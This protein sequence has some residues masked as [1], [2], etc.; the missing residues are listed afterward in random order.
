MNPVAA[1]LLA[2]ASAAMLVLALPGH[3]Q[4]Y[5]SFVAL[6]PLLLVIQRASARAALL[7]AWL[8]GGVFFLV[9]LSWIAHLT[10][11]GL[12]ALAFYLSLSFLLFAWVVRRLTAGPWRLPFLAVAPMAWVAFEQLRGIPLGGF[13]WH[14]L[15][16]NL[17]RWTTL[18]Q[19]ADVAGVS[20]LSLVVAFAGAWLARVIHVA[21][22]RE[23][24]TRLAQRNL[25]LGALLAFVLIAGTFVYGRFRLA[26]TRLVDG[27]VVS[28]VQANIPQE[29]S[30]IAEAREWP[31]AQVLA[32]RESVFN[33]YRE[34]TLAN[35]CDVSNDLIVWPETIVPPLEGETYKDG[36]CSSVAQRSVHDLRARLGRPM[37]V[38]STRLVVTE[39]PDNTVRVQSYNGA[40]FFGADNAPFRATFKKHLVPFGEFVPFKEIGVVKAVIEW[41]MPPGYVADLTPGREIVLFE[42]QGAAF[43]APICYEDTNPSLVREY[44]RLGARFLVNITNDGWFRDTFELDQ[45]LANAVFRTVENRVALVVAANTGISAF[46]TPTGVITA[47]LEDAHGRYRA[48]AGTLTSRVMLDERRALYTALGDWPA[49]GAVAWVGLFLLA[50]AAGTRSRK[51]E[52]SDGPAG[53]D[54]T[55]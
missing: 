14:C 33:A 49:W 32:K 53:T 47:R 54:V 25:A 50:G 8:A 18:I 23:L 48:V 4:G 55:Q 7:S 41:F 22:D 34:L 2:L 39:R 38:G 31:W 46:V 30:E 40:Y 26:E 3:E 13:Y 51:P 1:I 44:R 19:I 21:L 17:Y 35:L 52:A 15:G 28:V 11:I 24:G 9:G 10:L 16:H 36:D 5:L 12:V 29:L 27:P 45:H 43:A 42:V 6:V 37:L 20:G